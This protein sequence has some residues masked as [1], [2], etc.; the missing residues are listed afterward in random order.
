MP[1]ESAKPQ[2][3]KASPKR[4]TTSKKK[5]KGLGD[6][7]EKITEA[8]GIKSVVEAVAGEDCGCKERKETLNK[9]FPYH[10]TMN[11]EEVAIWK[12]LQPSVEKRVLSRT[13]Q[14][15]LRMLYNDL[16]WSGYRSHPGRCAKCW[17]QMI[18]RLEKI[19][20][21]TCQVK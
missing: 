4:K 16:H 21:D 15:K 18:S 20:K 19:Y 10:K 6:T 5:S 17:N 1:P 2:S 11:E 8:T 13:D 12:E 3:K 7:V 9:L 14:D